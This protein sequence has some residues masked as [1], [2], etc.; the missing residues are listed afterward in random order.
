METSE[1]QLFLRAAGVHCLQGF[2]FGKPMSA[3]EISAR[4]ARQ[5]ARQA[6]RSAI[7]V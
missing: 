4:L 6:A 7:A 3:D 1:Q 5:S 2:R